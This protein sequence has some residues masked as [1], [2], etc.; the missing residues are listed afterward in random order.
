[1]SN[2]TNNN[3]SGMTPNEIA[4]KKA[5]AEMNK[6]DDWSRK[7]SKT[8]RVQYN[9]NPLTCVTCHKVIPYEK[10][11]LYNFCSRECAET[12]F[13]HFK[14]V[15]KC[16]LSHG[17]D[18]SK[19]PNEPFGVFME[20]YSANKSM[21]DQV[22]KNVEESLDTLLFKSKQIVNKAGYNITVTL[23]DKKS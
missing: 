20:I 23:S 3:E 18:P 11:S 16:V 14:A 22:E 4:I 2:T 8:D 13:K 21:K 9:K 1:M 12:A 6:T 19:S 5:T 10:R 7:Y 17:F 15:D